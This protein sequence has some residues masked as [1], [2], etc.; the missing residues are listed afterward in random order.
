MPLPRETQAETPEVLIRRPA[1]PGGQPPRPVTTPTELAARRRPP[2]PKPLLRLWPRVRPYRRG[3]VI[4]AHAAAERRLALAFPLVVRYLLDAAFEHHDRQ[5]LDQIALGLL[6]L[7]ATTAVL[8]YIQTYFLS[9]TGERAVAG[10]REELFAKLL[11]MPPGFFADR[12]TG[13]LTSRLTVDIGLLQGSCPT[14]SPTSPGSSW[15]WW[16]ASCSSPGCS[17]T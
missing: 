2:S 1:G 7:F 12:R 14:R 5:L 9:A 4:A 10:L 6:A 8:N 15:H 16:A 13:E 11:D 17:R 3:L